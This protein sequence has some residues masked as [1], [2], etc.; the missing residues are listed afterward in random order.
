[1]KKKEVKQKISLKTL[2][3]APSFLNI[4]LGVGPTRKN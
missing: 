3:T 2:S 4:D 1:M